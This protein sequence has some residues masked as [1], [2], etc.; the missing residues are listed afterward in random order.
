MHLERAS[1]YP[2]PGLREML[3]ELGDGESGFS[4]TSFGRGE[5]DLETFLRECCEG[6]DAGKVKPGLVPQ[7]VYWII[8]DDNEVVGT[9]RVRPRLNERLLQNGGNVGYYVRRHARGRGYAKQAL[10]LAMDRLREF[11]VTRALLT[12]S[13]ANVASIRVVLGQGGMLD[14]QG[15]DA[16]GEALNR[17]WINLIPTL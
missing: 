9:I 10:R 15:I 5:A 17:Y 12:V 7:V 8:G 13:P 11:G 4:G 14:G 2:P 6:E 1:L 16:A 3:L